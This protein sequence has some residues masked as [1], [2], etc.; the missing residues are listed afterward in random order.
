MENRRRELEIEISN[1]KKINIQTAII[2]GEALMLDE[3]KTEKYYNHLIR[4]HIQLTKDVETTEN[5]LNTLSVVVENT[6][7]TLKQI[8]SVSVTL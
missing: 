6:Q 4:E 7:K 3:D 8:A 1:A 2:K 5:S